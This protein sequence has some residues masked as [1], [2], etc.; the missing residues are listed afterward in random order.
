MHPALPLCRQRRR[1]PLRRVP[2]QPGV[3]YPHQQQAW[4]QHRCHWPVLQWLSLKVAHHR[5]LLVPLL[6]LPPP[7]LVL[8]VPL[9]VAPP[10]RWLILS[11]YL[12]HTGREQRTSQDAQSVR[13]KH[14]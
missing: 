11:P 5:C 13:R 4:L 10:Q 14:T 12:Q 3:Q 1:L 6:P 7:L 8:L 2:P 9:K